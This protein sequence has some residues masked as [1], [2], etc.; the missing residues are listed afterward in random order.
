MK[1]ARLHSERLILEPFGEDH[2]PTLSVMDMDPDVM[3]YIRPASSNLIAAE[4]RIRDILM[5][6]DGQLGI[7]G[8]RDQESSIV[9]GMAILR[10][11]PD[12]SDIEVGYRLAKEHWG[13]GY[14]TEAT[15][16]LIYHGFAVLD[17]TDIVATF[18]AANTASRHV[19]EKCGLTDDGITTAYHAAGTP[20][21]RIT[22]NRWLARDQAKLA[23]SS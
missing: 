19:L 1:Q 6:D 11:L 20:R 10:P 22:R 23:A 5:R 4:N 15:T 9:I 3:R 16:R 7:W 13:K 12:N 2:I 14:A 18:D 17:L 8:L 21:V